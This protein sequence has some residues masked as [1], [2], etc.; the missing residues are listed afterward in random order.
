MMT[1]Y[2]MLPSWLKYDPE[3][4]NIAWQVIT[5]CARSAEVYT[6]FDAYVMVLEAIGFNADEI[7]HIAGSVY[8]QQD[9]VLQ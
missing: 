2:E 8:G 6:E 7:M 4:E 1:V 9:E 3:L 5:D